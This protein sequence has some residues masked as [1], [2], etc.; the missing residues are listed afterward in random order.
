MADQDGNYVNSFYMTGGV[1]MFAFVIPFGLIFIKRKRS[2][3]S[4]IVSPDMPDLEA[5]KKP[6]YTLANVT[7]GL[8]C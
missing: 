1:L 8:Q 4:P 7:K 5:R 2:P 3:V 6:F